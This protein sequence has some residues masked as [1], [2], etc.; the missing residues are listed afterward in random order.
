MYSN[1][2]ILL[3]FPPCFF[4][5]PASKLSFFPLFSKPPFLSF[6]LFS[7]PILFPLTILITYFVPSRDPSFFFTTFSSL[8]FFQLLNFPV[9]PHFL[10]FLIDISPLSFPILLT[11]YFTFTSLFPSFVSFL[12]L[13]YS[14]Y[15]FFPSLFPTLLFYYFITF[16]RFLSYSFLIHDLSFPFFSLHIF[17]FPFLFCSVR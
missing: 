8:L 7:F 3:I 6:F 10:S 13:S 9:F 16:L 5:F 17:T 12:I 2:P 15:P 1:L 11:S 14:P 4:H